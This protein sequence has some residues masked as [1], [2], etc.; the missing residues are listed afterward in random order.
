MVNWL[1]T[2]LVDFLRDQADADLAFS[3]PVDVM[4]ETLRTVPLVLLTSEVL[5]YAVVFAGAV[6]PE[7]REKVPSSPRDRML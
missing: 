7:K 1:S 3:T 2:Q 4:A 5:S 6:R